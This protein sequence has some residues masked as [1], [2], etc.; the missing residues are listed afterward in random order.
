MKYLDALTRFA[1]SCQTSS[2]VSAWTSP[3]PYNS[4]PARSFAKSLT[5]THQP[6]FHQLCATLSEPDAPYTD[7][8][9]AY[10]KALP[11]SLVGEAVRSALRSNRGICWDFT[12]N[13]FSDNGSESRLVSVVHI[14]GKGTRSFLNAKF[15]QSVPKQNSVGAAE[16]SGSTKLKLVQSGDAFE[17]GFL[18]AKGRI[19]DR[20]I[21]LAFL[22]DKSEDASDEAFLITS[23]GNSGSKLYDELA[24][25]VFPMDQ[26]TVTDF[27]SNFGESTQKAS[28]I[29][30][31]CSKLK[32]A[33]ISLQKNAAGL[34]LGDENAKFGYPSKSVCH[35]YQI[36]DT[37][38][39]M[40][41]HTFL[42]VEACHGYTLLFRG[43][44]SLSNSLWEKLTNEFNNDGPVGVAS[45]E[46]ETLRIEAGLPG[47]GYEMSGDGP[48][49]KKLPAD[50]DT[51]KAETEQ[52]KYYSKASPLELHLQY[53]VDTEKGCYQGQEGIAS[54]L[55]NKRGSPRT[56]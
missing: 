12:T 48:K 45:L 22:N 20:I 54:I 32:N 26:V 44:G 51:Q 29:T 9:S 46:Y 53:L 6:T 25:F 24:P 2:L 3:L 8:S 42:P 38:L 35:H 27:S 7:L 16:G 4:L 39:Y 41:E 36:G 28:V 49:K 56:L 19:I 11:P 40:L 33:Q 30:L 15:S 13:R 23:P 17:T 52:E 34:L 10:D 43:N 1:I 5:T 55:K 47:Y 18:T 50:A 31:A 14:S 21:I 37:D